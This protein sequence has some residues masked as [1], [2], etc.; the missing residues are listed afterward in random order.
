MELSLFFF[1]H[2]VP[3][4][5]CGEVG[6]GGAAVT[7]GGDDRVHGAGEFMTDVGSERECACGNTWT[8]FG[9]EEEG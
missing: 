6:E 3:V 4:L 8:S 2:T 9:V 7:A 5:S 1:F